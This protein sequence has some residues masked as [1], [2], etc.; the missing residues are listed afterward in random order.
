MVVY[1]VILIG[2]LVISSEGI[3][4]WSGGVW[5]LT[6]VGLGIG[7]LCLYQ[8][9][10]A[11]RWGAVG[12]V[13]ILSGVLTVFPLTTFLAHALQALGLVGLSLVFY[14]LE[15]VFGVPLMLPGGLLVLAVVATVLNTPLM[16]FVGLV[17][18]AVSGT[19]ALGRM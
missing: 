16:S 10:R 1:A 18:L 19:L 12:V 4:S 5:G 11:A 6:L 15:K 3:P 8:Q 2:S 9:Q 7:T 17:L 14:D 13:L